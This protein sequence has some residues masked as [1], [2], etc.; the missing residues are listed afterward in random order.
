MF[1]RDVGC[2]RGRTAY[3]CV[4][5]SRAAPAI[6]DRVTTFRTEIRRAY[7]RENCLQPFIGEAFESADAGALRLMTIGI[8][9]YLSE[10]DWPRQ[11]PEWFAG[12][13]NEGRHKFDRTVAKDAG[14][15]ASALAGGAS[16]F[17]GL[18]YRGK[19]NVFHTNAVKDYLPESKGKRSDQVA[20]EDFERHV[21]TW[22]AE[23]EIMAKYGVLPHVIIVFGRPFW[24]WAWK[25]FH[26]T[27]RP[28]F[29]HLKVHGFANAPGEGHH[30]AN[31][32]DLEGAGGRHHL[33]LLALR[34]PAAR[35]TSTATPEWLLSRPDVRKLLEPASP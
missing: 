17:A 21:P 24:E 27:S 33:A 29:T 15:I 32:I 34:H 23:L 12:W 20:R 9:A 7:E 16:R 35:A 30:F 8:N 25:A 19:E 22:H 14:A 31:L 6:L 1:A 3:Q 26:P 10:D 13:F 11:S 4:W 5:R 2:R 28:S 18:T